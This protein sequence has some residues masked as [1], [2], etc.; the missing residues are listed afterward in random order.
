VGAAPTVEWVL[1]GIALVGFM[2]G[3]LNVALGSLVMGR[4]APDERGRVG[5]L[6]TGVASGMQIIAFAAGGALASVLEPRTIFIAAGL[7]GVLVPLALGPGLIRSARATAADEPNPAAT[8]EPS[9]AA[10]VPAP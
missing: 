10:P 6:L 3:V 2:N 8:P 9:V 1:P 4:S 7:L 5:A